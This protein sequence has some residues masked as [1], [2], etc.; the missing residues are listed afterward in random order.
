MWDREGIARRVAQ[1]V[2]RGDYVNLGIG[3]PTLVANHLP[4]GVLIELHSE[5][6]LLGMGPDADEH[7]LDRDLV[8]AG[9]FPV[10]YT[11]GASICDSAESFAMI[12]GGHI[13]ITVLG[14]MEVSEHGDLA[15][16]KIPGKRV[17]GMG[18]AMDLV[19]GARYIIVAM[20]HCNKRGESKLVA[21]CSMPLTGYHCVQKVVTDL[22]VFDIL[23]EGGFLLT[24]CAPDVSI[25]YIRAHT[26]GRLE[27]ALETAS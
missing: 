11:D 18:G 12:R 23:P 3:I 9:E 15:N 19:A 16:W 17:K 22:G 5:N 26:A 4:E 10:C 27:I 13:D 6:G 7:H 14:G 25:D 1:E 8:N 2:K 24:E 21:Q 20:Q